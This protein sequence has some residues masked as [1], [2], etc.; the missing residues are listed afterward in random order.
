MKIENIIKNWGVHFIVNPRFPM[1]VAWA[2]F[3]SI[4]DLTVFSYG[5]MIAP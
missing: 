5:I 3:W 1:L 2:I 4:I